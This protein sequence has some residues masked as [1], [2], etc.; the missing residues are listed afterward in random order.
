MSEH[1]RK[2]SF[3][4]RTELEIF[5]LGGEYSFDVLRLDS[6]N[7]RFTKHCLGPRSVSSGLPENIDEVIRNAVFFV[8]LFHFSNK[9]DAIWQTMMSNEGWLASCFFG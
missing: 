6:K 1:G 4:R 9:I 5:E 7:T 8:C 3:S 2:A